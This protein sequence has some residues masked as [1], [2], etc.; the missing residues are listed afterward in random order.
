MAPATPGYSSDSSCISTGDLAPGTD[1]VD[2]A[3][4]PPSR[5]I[6]MQRVLGNRAVVALLRTRAGDVAEPRRPT[7]PTAQARMDQAFGEDFSEVTIHPDS[8]TPAGLGALAYTQGNDV[9]FAPGQF[10]PESPEG[11]SL[12]AHEL[13][14]V[15]QQRQGSVRGKR[16]AKGL[17]VNESPELEQQA[18]AAARRAISFPVKTSR[19]PTPTWRVATHVGSERPGH[20]VQLFKDPKQTAKER[21]INLEERQYVSTKGPAKGLAMDPAKNKGK[22]MAAN[23]EFEAQAE[24]FEYRLGVAAFH[25]PR[26]NAVAQALCAKI[27]AYLQAKM[28]ALEGFTAK[29][30]ELWNM[31]KTLIGDK[32]AYKHFAG[33]VGH[34]LETG[35]D[36]ELGREP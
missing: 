9:H 12:L 20:P 29:V 15:V 2:G 7:L 1:A 21:G 10:N 28:D 23:P 32:P 18:D 4:L 17:A 35:T 36:E 34:P 11:L 26:S 8:P 13:A 19:S 30:T 27:D 24:A 5:I 14:H 31:C 16:Q 33:T 22:S 3:I 6:Q 25:D